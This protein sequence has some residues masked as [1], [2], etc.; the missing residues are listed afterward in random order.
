MRSCQAW[1]ICKEVPGI[2]SDSPLLLPER[3]RDHRMIPEFF[4]SRLQEE[5]YEKRLYT[6]RI[7]P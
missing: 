5:L 1:N 3:T 2:L 6:G 4:C 7:A